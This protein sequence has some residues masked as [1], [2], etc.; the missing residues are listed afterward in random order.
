MTEEKPPLKFWL[1]GLGIFGIFIV[2][3]ALASDASQNNIVDHQGAST[4]EM[5]NTIQA[6]WRANGLRNAVIYGMIVDF[7]LIAVFG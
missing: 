2:L 4:A 3:G 1:S 6:D 7:V 5:L